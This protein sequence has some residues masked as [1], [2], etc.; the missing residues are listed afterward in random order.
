MKTER[1]KVLFLPKWYPNR[2]DSLDGIF[3]ENHAKAV[4]FFSDVFVLYVG[5]TTNIKRQ[6]EFEEE[7][8]DGIKILKV[9]FK[10]SFSKIKILNKL[11]KLGF[12]FTCLFLGFLRIRKKYGL[13]TIVHVHVLLRSAVLALVLKYVYQIN[14]FITE[15]S[16]KYLTMSKERSF[17][18]IL[19]KWVIN[20]SE[21]LSVVSEKL[22]EAIISLGIDHNKV[23]VI[24]NVVNE[25]HF[26][27]KKTSRHAISPKVILHVSEFIEA[28]KNIKGILRTVKELSR[29][30]EDFILNIIGYGKDEAE[31]IQYAEELQIKDKL[32]FFLGKIPQNE[33]VEYYNNSSF[34]LLFSHFE[35]FGCVLIESLACGKPVVAPRVGGIP[36]IINEENGILVEVGN[37]ARLLVHLNNMLESF[38]KYDPYLLRENAIKK[39]S[40][41]WIGGKFLH[42][43]GKGFF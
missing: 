17:R 40:F 39:Y 6:V 7:E 26:Y 41:S 38:Q 15:H 30:R 5:S 21:K 43:Y 14:F 29:Q 28:S 25:A 35:T 33:L 9:Y 19:L 27:I 16:S 2:N 36:E 13:P 12:Y 37:E 20:R 4:S 34:F 8:L 42:F 3:I 24:P 18:K 32:V 1:A 10:E 31:I 22:K 23:E 11:I